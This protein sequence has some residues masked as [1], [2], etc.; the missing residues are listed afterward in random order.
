MT[1][2]SVFENHN[3]E[4]VKLFESMS[5]KFPFWDVSYSEDSNSLRIDVALAGYS[6]NDVDISVD[7]GILKISSGGSTCE[8]ENRS[9]CVNGI[10]KRKFCLKFAI[11]RDFEVTNAS[12]KDGLLS[13]FVTKVK[14]SSTKKI[15][16]E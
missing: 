9:Y 11:S 1:L 14:T 15:N 12:M 13:V 4:I 2:L 5:K 8:Q 3:K 7:N 6:K 10:A 16:I